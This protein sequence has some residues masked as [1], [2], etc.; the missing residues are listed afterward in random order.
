[1]DPESAA[2]G[3]AGLLPL[4]AR[5]AKTAAE[6]KDAVISAKASIAAL[7]TELDALEDSAVELY[8]FLKGESLTS[9]NIRL[10]RPCLILSCTAGCEAKLKLLCRKLSQ[11]G[12]GRRNRFL[13][14]FS[15]KE[16]Q[17]II[18]ELHT[19]TTWMH[20]AS[21]VQGC[22]LL[23]R[24]LNDVMDILENQLGQLRAV[25][26]PEHMS[27]N[28]DT[29]QAQ[30]LLLVET[31]AR[32]VRQATLDWISTTRYLERHE[33]LRLSRAKGT[34]DWILRNPDY[35]RWRD[36]L[37]TASTLWCHGKQGSGKTNLV[38]IIVDN[39]LHIHSDPPK[40]VAFFYF[41]HQD[42]AAQHPSTV[43]ACLLRQLVEQLPDIP[44][45]VGSVYEN[46]NT[47][48]ALPEFE[49]QRLL[50]EL[51]RDR[52]GAYIVLDALDEY[53]SDYRTS[54]LQTIAQFSKVSGARVLLTSS[55]E[56]QEIP[57]TLRKHQSV[58][59][60][61]Q[62]ADIKRYIRQELG[63]KGVY[64]LAD[65]EF[66]GQLV[67]KLAEG[68]DGM[69]LLPVLQLQGI[70]REP[71]LGDMED[72]LKNLSRG[73]NEVLGETIARIRNLSDNRSRVGMLT[74]MYLVHAARP[75]TAAELSDLLAIH[76]DRKRVEQKYR[77][78]TRMILECCQGLVTIDGKTGDVRTSHS[79]IQEYL[80]ANDE[81][82][83]PRAEAI[84]AINCLRYIQ[85]SDF[86][87]GPWDTGAE[88]KSHMDKYPFLNY[89]TRFWGKHAYPS[90]ADAA[91]Q[92][93]LSSFFR[94][95]AATAV[96]NQVRQFAMGRK[97]DYWSPEECL[98]FTPLHHACRH[99]LLRTAEGLLDE[100]TIDVN[101][102]TKQRATALIHAASSGHVDIIRLLMERGADP[103]LCNWYGNALHCAVQA[104]FVDTVRELVLKWGMNPTYTG[105]HRTYLGCTLDRDAA[106]AFE[107]LIDL[108][109]DINTEKGWGRATGGTE[110]DV[111]LDDLHIFLEACSTGCYRIVDLLVSRGWV[112]VNMKSPDGWTAL[113]WA[114]RGRN[115]TIV[116]KLVEAGADI[117]ARDN[118]GILALDLVQQSYDPPALEFV[119]GSYIQ[120]LRKGYGSRAQQG[121]RWGTPVSQR[122]DP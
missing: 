92:A 71:T 38:S 45:S 70:L 59:I 23:S 52:K 54:L 58:K 4:I 96:T 99:G 104:G 14:P 80:L 64:E 86:E 12:N 82:L 115:L 122:G 89:A 63:A 91:V 57:S 74:L 51:L 53:T 103:Y 88:I 77:P 90:E 55:H 72:S 49:C 69:F 97:K 78:T 18:Q 117:T 108:G 5:A 87:T 65:D 79:S 66:V 102:A 75:L 73:L 114:A 61:A 94:S 9:S 109:V 19:F 42:Q 120:G 111:E 68:A 28:P 39:L 106:D 24:P 34:G 107:T 83:F 31:R 25:Q 110:D 15:E 21:S 113:H 7:T 10:H 81:R 118:E 37:D 8:E 13:W 84:F 101:Q 1:M 40:P 43:L 119:L 98:S 48:G 44:H 3:I 11:D 76:A 41:D 93:Q 29:V 26:L 33:A 105:K 22:R 85:L 112:D 27:K 50:T 47:K 95:R 116:K 6:Y 32:Q 20:F 67:Q 60:V 46:S 62:E 16:D 17:K 2:V 36:G 30:Q 35:I 56:T 100:G 121:D